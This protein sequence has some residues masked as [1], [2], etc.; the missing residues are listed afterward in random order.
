MCAT[1]LLSHGCTLLPG[2]SGSGVSTVEIVVH[3]VSEGETLS[4]IA[5]DYYG[6][7]RATGYLAEV[8]GIG[9]DVVLEPGEVIEVPVGEDDLERYRRR[10]EAK[11]Y[12]NRGTVL[13][14]AGDYGAAREE[15]ALA[16]KTDPRF[17]DA[18]YNLGVVL[19]ASGDPARAAAVLE[20]VL[21]VRPED[22]TTEFALGKA[23]FDAGRAEEAVGH[24]DRAIAL[25]PDLED[26]H[27][28]RAVA[29]LSAGR[30]EEAVFALDSYLRRFPD[31][32]WS[33]QARSR[34]LQMA[35]EQEDQ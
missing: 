25:D 20:Q 2:R 22:A 1:G 15:F 28:A 35:R 11:I 33:P 6:T 4:M 24:F 26:A 34:L 32:A 27:F 16:L 13:A 10:T 8:N 12:Y 17:V 29:L 18:G 19:M 3:E 30:R 5:D 21:A 7:P 23:L 9:P 14:E 31:G